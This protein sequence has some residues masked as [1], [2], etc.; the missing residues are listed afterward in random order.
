MKRLLFKDWGEASL[1]V[2]GTENKRQRDRDKE[3]AKEKEEEEGREKRG[4]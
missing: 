1:R 2:R 3:K 4:R